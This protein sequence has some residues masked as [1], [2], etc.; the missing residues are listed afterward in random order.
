MRQRG[1]ETAAA[2]AGAVTLRPR[3]YLRRGYATQ[4]NP[5]SSPAGNT[6]VP[7]SGRRPAGHRL[8]PRRYRMERELHRRPP[9]Y[10]EPTGT[11]PGRAGPCH[12]PPSRRFSLLS[13]PR[14]QS[15]RL[16]S[17]RPHGPNNPSLPAYAGPSVLQMGHHM[18][19]GA[20]INGGCCAPP[21]VAVSLDVVRRDRRWSA[22]DCSKTTTTTTTTT[23]PTPRP[24]PQP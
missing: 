24:Q 17:T 2:A 19:G 21:S 7:R 3:G 4:E 18:A 13:P 1:C 5:A 11:P 10:P 9:R 12:L 15:S 20:M 6:S 22:F 23:M 14:S 8:S 16:W